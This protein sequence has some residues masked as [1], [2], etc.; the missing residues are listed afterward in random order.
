[1]EIPTKR[2]VERERERERQKKSKTF[3]AMGRHLRRKK[4][5]YPQR[6]E[7]NQKIGI[8]QQ[9]IEVRK[10]SWY[11]LFFHPKSLIRDINRGPMSGP[12]GLVETIGQFL[13]FVAGGSF[14]FDPLN[15]LRYKKKQGLSSL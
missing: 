13:A 1:M 4:V 7:R 9:A 5:C 15:L 6:D 12:T 14:H 2:G 3:W 10:N 11:L 8:G